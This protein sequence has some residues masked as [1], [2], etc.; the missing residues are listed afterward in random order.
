MCT[1]EE[2]MSTQGR[3]KGGK[4]G[5]KK[6]S[7]REKPKTA[8]KV[9]ASTDGFRSAGVSEDS[10]AMQTPIQ[11]VS[12]EEK[13][14]LIAEAAYFRSEKRSFAPGYELEDWLTA[15][16]E[17]ETKISGTGSSEGGQ[18]NAGTRPRR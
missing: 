10:A 3:P 8:L 15:E 5:L 16:S 11:G 6:M 9:S 12:S 2:I 14:R 1:S 13:Y 7:A 18:S 4:T 17:I